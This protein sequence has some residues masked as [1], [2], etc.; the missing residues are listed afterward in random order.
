V[1][2]LRGAVRALLLVL[3]CVAVGIVGLVISVLRLFG[4]R[5]DRLALYGV[6]WLQRIWCRA[7]LA[8]LAVRVTVHGR[9]PSAPC[10]VV[11]NH[12]SYL[13][14]G[15]LGAQGRMRF[16]SKAELAGWPLFG[17]LAR[18]ARVIFLTR[19]RR[20]DLVRVGDEIRA[21]LRAGV[22][23][24]FFPEGTS[25]PGR[26]VGPFHPGLLQ[27][28]AEAALPCLPVTL[29]YETPARS[30]PPSLAVCWWGDMTFPPHFWRLLT[31]PH[32]DAEVRWGETPVTGRDRKQLAARLHAQ[33]A[34][35][36]VPLRQATVP[37]APTR[38]EVAV[39]R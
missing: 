8:L 6:L 27:P 7:L 35:A 3:I 26:D 5:G 1:G 19:G 31:L 20:R 37:S 23:V 38:A 32:V 21:S 11:G 16:V 25:S 2:A 17:Q 22:P 10:L 15:V 29:R 24:V 13:D 4:A 36:F 30:P 39:P 12:L 9:P 28:A 33:V 18:L 14:I 34:A